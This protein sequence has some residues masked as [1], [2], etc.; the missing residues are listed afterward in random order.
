MRKT[1]LILLSL[2]PLGVLHAQ[3]DTASAPIEASARQQLQHYP[4]STLKDLYKNFFQ[5]AFGPGHLFTGEADAQ[6]AARRYV[7]EECL[8]TQQDG[9]PGPLY[10][11]TGSQGRFYRVNLSVI[12]TGRVPLD[13]FMQ[14]FL[15]SARQFTLPPLEQWVEEWKEIEAVI[16]RICPQL[17]GLDEDSQAIQALLQSGQYASHHSAAYEAAYRP[18]Y[19]LIERTIFQEQ[20]L[21][22]LKK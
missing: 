11:L 2:L 19:R 20:L 1:L 16:R 10:E 9:N 18:H 14:A 4:A 12:T 17:P 22:L 6:T 13:T 5:D 21:P 7:E 15:Q 3:Q 8:Q